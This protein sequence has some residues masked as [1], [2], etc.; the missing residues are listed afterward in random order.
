[1]SIS[2]NYKEQEP[3]E[4]E[5]GNVNAVRIEGRAPDQIGQDKEPRKGMQGSHHVTMMGMSTRA[6]EMQGCTKLH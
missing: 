1:M 3:L 2:N 6:R 5:A 4:E